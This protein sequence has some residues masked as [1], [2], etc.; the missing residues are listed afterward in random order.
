MASETLT[1]IQAI[2]LEVQEIRTMLNTY[3]DK[4]DR[5]DKMLVSGDG[6]RLPLAEIVRNLS[7]TVQEYIAQKDKEEQLKQ[8]EWRKIKTALILAGIPLVITFI[9]Q[10]VVFYFKIIPLIEKLNP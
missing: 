4:V 7:K 2:K 6:D 5:H 3:M 8:D 9:G 10:A 1:A